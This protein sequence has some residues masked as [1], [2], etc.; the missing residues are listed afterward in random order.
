M[1][2][3]R[4]TTTLPRECSSDASISSGDCPS[5]AFRQTPRRSTETQLEMI[6]WSCEHG[7]F[8]GLPPRH[9]A[10]EAAAGSGHAAAIKH[11]HQSLGH[12][13]FDLTVQL[14]VAWMHVTKTMGKS[15]YCIRFT[16]CTDYC[17]P[18]VRLCKDF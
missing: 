10:H 9:L 8:P 14:H 1:A 12:L 16:D 2:H 11:Q 6:C 13:R 17:P 15:R 3:A 5:A 4:A 18:S 7:F